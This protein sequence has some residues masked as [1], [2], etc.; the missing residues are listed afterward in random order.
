M[1]SHKEPA[2]RP[3]AR[4]VEFAEKDALPGAELKLSLLDNNRYAGTGEG[5]HHVC[6]SIPLKMAVVLGIWNKAGQGVKYIPLHI[7][8]STFVDGQSGSGVGIVEHQEAVLN[9]AFLH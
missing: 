4:A 1:I 8:V 9:A 5:G 6:G 2:E 7:R 3:A